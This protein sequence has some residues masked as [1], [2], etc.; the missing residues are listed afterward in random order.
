MNDQPV[1]HQQ[2]KD[3][4]KPW[5]AAYSEKFDEIGLQELYKWEAIYHFQQHWDLEAND[6]ATMLSTSLEKTA[7]LLSTQN[8]FPGG[9]ITELAEHEPETVRTAFRWLFN[10]EGTL[11]DRMTDFRQYASELTRLF[12]GEEKSDYQDHRAVSIFLTLRYPARYGFY[13]YSVFKA[14]SE[15]IDYPHPP[16][17]GALGNLREWTCMLQ[18]ITNVLS[19]PENANLLARHQAR[20]DETCYQGDADM[21]LA[22]DI[23]Y[24]MKYHLTE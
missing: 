8:Y 23:A 22:Q 10:E 15:K 14:A 16:K 7:N 12:V 11:E 18:G 24:A 19:L 5:L 17:R 6:F 3:N 1:P 2:W 20:L 13:M 9:M 21:L 4:L